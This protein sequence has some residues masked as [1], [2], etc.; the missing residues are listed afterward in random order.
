MAE[1]GLHVCLLCSVEAVA[2]RPHACLC[3]VHLTDGTGSTPETL[4]AFIDAQ[5]V[6]HDTIGRRR[7]ACAIGTHDMRFVQLGLGLDQAEATTAGGRGA[8]LCIDARPPEDVMLV[9]L[10]AAADVDGRVDAAAKEAAAEDKDDEAL[11]S[12]GLTTTPLPRPAS[13]VIAAALANESRDGASSG[14]KNGTF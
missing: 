9:P 4:K 7:E 6:I 5:T 12:A 8:A 10:K 1:C 13:D 2:V 14:A 11:T 3:V